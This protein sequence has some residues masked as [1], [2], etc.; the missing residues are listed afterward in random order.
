V[1]SAGAFF[2]GHPDASRASFLQWA[3]DVGALAR[4]PELLGIGEAVIV[5]A[6][7]LVA[8]K[9]AVTGAGTGATTSAFTVV[10]PGKR[11]FYCFSSDG[12][13][14]NALAAEPIGEDLCAGVR[15]QAMLAARDS[16]KPALQPSTIDGLATLALGSP[17]YRGGVVPNSVA[18]RRAAFVGWVGMTILPN[19][20]LAT[21]LGTHA[22]TEVTLKFGSDAGSLLFR[23]GHAPASAQATSLDLHD[24]WTVETLAISSSGDLFSNNDALWLLATGLLL[25]GLL[26][27]LIYVL[28]TGRGRAMRLVHERTDELQFQTLHDALTGLPNR[29]LLLDRIASMLVRAQR[30]KGPCA[31]MFLDL[32]DF[33]DINDTLGHDAGDE[34]LIAVGN[35]LTAALR[36]GDTAGRL[37]GD[38]FLVLI[39]GAALDDGVSAVA[40]RIL[41][42][43]ERPFEVRAS[44]V[45]LSISASIGIATGTRQT[46]SEL[47]RDADIAL[48]RAKAGGKR[49]SVIFAPSMQA[50][51]DD[52]R[53]L[54]VALHAAAA[55]DQFFL[56]Y[57]P[58]IDM[59][60]GQI[61]GVE[62]LLRWRH[63]T[64]GTIQP[65][66]FIPALEAS[67]MIV[68]VGAWVL[69]EACW[70]GAAWQAEGHRLSV[71]V[72]VSGK[73]LARDRIVDDV[74]HALRSS[75][76]EP[77]MLTLELTETSLMGDVEETISRLT[78]LRA[79]GVKI[80]IDDFGTGYASVAYLRQF[81]VDILK[82]DRAF[83]VAM[84]ESSEG[85]AFVH[86]IVQ[87]GKDLH[88]KTVAEGIEEDAQL[89]QVQAEGVDTGQG[90]LIS[91]PI[92]ATAVDD[93]LRASA[94][95]RRAQASK[96][97]GRAGDLARNGTTPTAP[98]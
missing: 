22:N 84:A 92:E 72:N 39:E 93:L 64:R 54:D 26:G 83:V 19:V 44:A 12:L 80:A 91:R 8:F 17:M 55:A 52:H 77:E 51:V 25:S 1:V 73:Q 24:G 32:D 45:P 40:D 14:R 49:R 61:N 79:L 68:P 81:P 60:S 67:G 75:G 57:Q 36:P 13:A 20:I 82:I 95:A 37:G 50:A 42:A 59:R 41:T 21:A 53:H 94:A 27:A 33:K 5:P 66:E 63:P 85:A 11:P 29:T 56:L 4:Y 87:L 48:Y 28:G 71:A 76:L 58:T 78:L 70:Q 15:G 9:R 74:A 16:G 6:S 31:V 62:A 35:R 7:A 18:G 2:L 34:L 96:R 90:F 38:E 3:R 69:V 65:N 98:H 47:L 88:L 86:T 89:R 43:I 23:S 46:P 30:A 97:P 10:P